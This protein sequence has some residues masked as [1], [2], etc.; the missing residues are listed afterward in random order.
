[1]AEVWMVA[2]GQDHE[3]LNKV[4]LMFDNELAARR[5]G[6]KIDETRRAC[7]WAYEQAKEGLIPWDEVPDQTVVLPDGT[8]FFIGQ[9][10][11]IESFPLRSVSDC[12]TPIRFSE[13]IINREVKH[14]NE[15]C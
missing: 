15:R 14:G 7:E 2:S 13:L 10:T 1:M 4:K 9:W 8:K 12:R 11:H 3:G 6:D 5:M